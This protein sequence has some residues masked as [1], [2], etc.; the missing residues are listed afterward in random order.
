MEKGRIQS[1]QSL[2]AQ[3]LYEREGKECIETKEG[4]ITY[5]INGEECY[6]E[7]VYILP[8]YRRLNMA[9]NLANQVVEVAKTM[10]CKFISGSVDPTA[11]AATESTKV[12]LAYGFKMHSIKNGLIWFTKRIHGSKLEENLA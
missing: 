2:Y 7:T 3:F 8:L 11:K 9:A 1:T 5:V 12:L 4:F 10:G 6:I